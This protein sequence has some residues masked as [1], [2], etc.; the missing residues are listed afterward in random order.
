MEKTRIAAPPKVKESIEELLDVQGRN[1][2]IKPAVALST[3]TSTTTAAPATTS[4]RVEPEC[5]CVES[6]KCRT[7]KV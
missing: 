1:V 7:D 6:S 5:D 2:I 3:T 4:D